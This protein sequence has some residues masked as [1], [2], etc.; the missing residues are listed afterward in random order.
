MDAPSSSQLE[1][2]EIDEDVKQEIELQGG[3]LKRL[4]ANIKEG[5]ADPQQVEE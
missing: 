3:L 4:H 2:P 5:K 1:P